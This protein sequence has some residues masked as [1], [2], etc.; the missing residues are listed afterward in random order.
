MNDSLVKYLI[1]VNMIKYEHL[2]KLFKDIHIQEDEVVLHLDIWHVFRRFFRDQNAH[3]FTTVPEDILVREIVVGFMNVIGHYRKYISAKLHKDNVILVYFNPGK[4]VYHTKLYPD[5]KSKMI[6]LLYDKHHKDY[7]VINTILGKSVQLI[8]DFVTRVEG[9]YWIYNYGVDTPTAMHYTMNT[10]KYKNDFHILFSREEV[11]TQLVSDHCIQFYQKRGDGS[12]LVTKNNFIKNGIGKSKGKWVE[13]N[14]TPKM[15]RFIFAL[16][17]VSDIEGKR[18][19]VTTNPTLVDRLTKLYKDD[20][21]YEDSSIQT[22]VK[23]LKSLDKKLVPRIE[24]HYDF[25]V[26]RYQL[27]DL[28][29]SAKAISKTSIQHMFHAHFD[30]YDQDELEKLNTLLLDINDKTEI[31]SLDNLNMR[32]AVKWN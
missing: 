10:P 17:G 27:Y 5:Y 19:S 13:S 15:S 1:G 9:V 4:S 26:T 29:I 11:L 12:Y 30:L 24:E 21:I 18:I 20:K 6:E 28:W 25:I 2:D 3:F 16:N 7:S 22:V 32:N 14:L 23:E 8:M 31:I